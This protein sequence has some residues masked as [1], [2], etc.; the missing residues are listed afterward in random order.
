MT[1]LQL[2]HVLELIDRANAAD[3]HTEIADGVERPREWLYGQ[4]MSTW[5]QRICPDASEHLKIAARG[6][7]I[8]R[9]EVPRDTYPASREGYL[10]WR[11]YL[12]RFHADHLAELMAAAGYGAADI[13][14]VGYIVQKRG[15]KTDPEVQTLEDVICLVFLEHHLAG[16]AASQDPDKLVEI[17]RKTWRKM[18]ERGHDFALQLPFS[19]AIRPLLA[20]A[21]GTA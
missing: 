14:R 13:E 2:G 5:L 21:L 4:R 1:A 19:D 7:H 16:F 17:V 3:P 11:T 6:Q 20:K 18:S 10:Q 12:Y 15:L 9:W 8:R